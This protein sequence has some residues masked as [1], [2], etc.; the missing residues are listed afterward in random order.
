ME[1]IKGLLI[2]FLPSM[3]FGKIGFASAFLYFGKNFS[4]IFAF[5]VGGAF[6]GSFIF[7][8]LSKKIFNWWYKRF[9]SKLKH[10]KIKK[11]RKI[12]QIKQKWGLSGIALLA[13]VLLSYP[14]GCFIAVKFFKNPLKIILSMTLSASLWTAFFYFFFDK[15]F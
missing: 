11:I 12:I 5:V 6:V 1:W 7:T 13:P 10:S 8:Y 3:F 15:I 14:G 4:A 9:P 2:A